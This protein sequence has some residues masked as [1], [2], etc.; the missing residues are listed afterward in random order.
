M[1]VAPERSAAVGPVMVVG[2]LMS[3]W[4]GAM[5]RCILE[6]GCGERSRSGLVGVRGLRR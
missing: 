5:P 4:S 1:A 2:E 3:K 6:V